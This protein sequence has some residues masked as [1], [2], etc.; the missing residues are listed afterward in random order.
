MAITKLF[1]NCFSLLF[2]SSFSLFLTSHFAAF[3][4]QSQTRPKPAINK[5]F[6]L[7]VLFPISEHVMAPQ[8]TFSFVGRLMHVHLRGYVCIIKEKNS[9]KNITENKPYRFRRSI[10]TAQTR[11]RASALLLVGVPTSKEGE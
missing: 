1:S 11:T 8:G 10:C 4:A 9:L 5:L 2:L 6:S 3:H 7:N